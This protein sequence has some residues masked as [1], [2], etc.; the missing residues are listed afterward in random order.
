MERAYKMKLNELNIESIESISA[1]I[2]NT[3]KVDSR[4]SPDAVRSF[5]QAHGDIEIEQ[6]SP[7]W[8]QSVGPVRG[9]FS[10]VAIRLKD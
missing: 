10:S 8:M 9:K 7:G 3:K 1:V 4:R 2:F 5:V 6:H